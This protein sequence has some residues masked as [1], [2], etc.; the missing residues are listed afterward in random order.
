MRASY[1]E[2]I[3]SRCRKAKRLLG[4]W[5]TAWTFVARPRFS[6]LTWKGAKKITRL[7]RAPPR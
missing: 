4:R 1:A 3:G 5:S 6:T 2:T 7:T